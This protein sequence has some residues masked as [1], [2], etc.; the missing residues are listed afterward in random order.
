[1]G[2]LLIHETKR[3]R[4]RTIEEA[5][6]KSKA[7]ASKIT[8]SRQGIHMPKKKKNTS[9]R[10]PLQPHGVVQAHQAK[11]KEPTYAS[12]PIAMKMM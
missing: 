11:E 8:P 6:T 4:S 2:S 5:T 1:M 9:R 3:K 7:I 12:W 10:I